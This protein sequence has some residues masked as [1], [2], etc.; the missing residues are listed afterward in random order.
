MPSQPKV[1]VVVPVYNC[2]PYLE[3][4]LRSVAAQSEQDIEII[5]ADDGSSDGSLDLAKRFASRDPRVSVCSR[6][7]SGYPGV[8]RNFG[9]CRATGRYVALLDGDDL[10]HSEKIERSLEVFENFE[11]VDV[12][13]HD[14]TPFHSQPDQPGS[15][16]RS[17]HFHNRAAAWL[18]YTGGRTYLCRRD[19][20]RFASV[21][22][23]PCHVSSTMFR[24]S[25]LAPS[26]PW[27]RED[28]RNG[29][30]GD[31]WLRLL[32]DRRA[33]FIDELL[34]FYR[35][36]ARSISSDLIKHLKGS[37]QL[38]TE[39]LTRGADVFS[40]DEAR[41]YKSK[42][43]ALYCDLGYQYFCQSQARAA[44]AAYKRSM[45]FTFRPKS[46]AAYLKT[47]APERAVRAYRR[48]QQA[49]RSARP[50]EPSLSH[51][52]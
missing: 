18:D 51:T 24:R 47:F 27:F 26:G 23:V 31:F 39:N 25:A 52:Q 7:N 41:R 8:T 43:A 40:P 44:R 13:F 28:L 45:S 3:E 1:S 49:S 15:F 35:I 6:P 38:H 42:I 4:C 36:R 10:Y 46:L 11:D 12:V 20:Y 37:V 17:T 48:V 30:D 2:E 29:D 9:L 33:A 14:Y 34:S 50:E 21:E 16:L 5:V 19:F 32:K 22:F